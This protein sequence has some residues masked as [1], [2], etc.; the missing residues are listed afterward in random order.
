MSEDL[1]GPSKIGVNFMPEPTKDELLVHGEYND[2][3][4]SCHC[5]PSTVK[6]CCHLR[7][8]RSW[9]T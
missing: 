8:P 9:D 6:N 4:G 2:E 5:K 1:Q 7:S 3:E